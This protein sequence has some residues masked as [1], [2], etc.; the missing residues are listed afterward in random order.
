MALAQPVPIRPHYT[1]G[2]SVVGVD[3]D[4]LVSLVEAAEESAE[5]T[6]KSV[7]AIQVCLKVHTELLAAHR[8]QRVR[9]EGALQANANAQTRIRERIKEAEK[10]RRLEK[11]QMAPGIRPRRVP[12]KQPYFVDSKGRHPPRNKDAELRHEKVKNKIKDSKGRGASNSA[13]VLKL[14]P[15]LQK[16][17]V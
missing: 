15:R 13:L 2:D 5:G 14:N 8:G 11:K 16:I 12:G 1:L 4:D 6:A 17:S 10:Q 7:Q 3:G 9:I